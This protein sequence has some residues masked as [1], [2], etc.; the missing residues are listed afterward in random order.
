[1]RNAGD[2]DTFYSAEEVEEIYNRISNIVRLE[3]DIH[4]H[5]VL[6][7][8]LNGQGWLSKPE[9]IINRQMDKLEEYYIR[10]P[11]SKKVGCLWLILTITIISCYLLN[12]TKITTD[13]LVLFLLIFGSIIVMSF[14]V[15]KD[16]RDAKDP[17]KHSESGLALRNRIE[18]DIKETEEELNRLTI[19]L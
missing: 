7:E 11:L 13:L 1:I 18:N 6:L 17:N 2:T 9:K 14:A 8:V 10:L 5:R 3:E 19:E 12:S 4:F 15:I 16:D